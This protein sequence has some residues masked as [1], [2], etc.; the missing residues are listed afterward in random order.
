MEKYSLIV[1]ISLFSLVAQGQGNSPCTATL[2]T[3]NA[4]AVCGSYTAGTTVGATYSNNAANGGT[5][6]CAS[7]GAPDVWYYFVAP[8]SGNINIYTSGGSITDGGMQLY[9]SS[10]NLCSGTLTA[11]NCDDDSGPGWMPQLTLCGLTP[12]NT[13][14]VRFWQYGGAGTGTFN[15][16]FWDTYSN[17]VASTNCNGGAQVCSN[18][19]FT[20]LG[21]GG[22]VQELTACNAGCLG[23]ENNSSWYWLNIGTTGSLEMTITPS[24][25][26]DDYDFAIWGPISVCPPLTAP[27]RCNYAAYPRVAGCGTNTNP[28]GMTAAGTGTSA[29]SCQN[30]PYLTPL[31]VTAGQ[32]YILLIDGYTPSSQPFTLSWGGTAGLSCTPIVLPIELLSFTGKNSGS[33]N[34]LDWITTTEVNNDFFTLEKSKDGINFSE[35]KRVKGAGMS[36]IT[37]S[38]QIY[39]DEPYSGITYYRLKQTD[40]NGHSQTFDV[41]SVQSCIGACS[42]ASAYSNGYGGIV[43]NINEKESA[44]YTIKVFDLI[45]NKLL[46][47]TV[48]TQKGNNSLIIDAGA[49]ST[50]VYFVSFETATGNVT[51]QKLLIK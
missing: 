49:I 45:G 3:V 28:T 1:V 19:S 2:M 15:I 11:Y 24:N 30:R 9:G 29:T 44:F 33:R 43:V 37:N 38:Y 20:G 41:I 18:N 7:P 50:G 8:A 46:M 12:G 16:C 47:E 51:T 10:N 14:W 5:P 27:V 26:T 21:S 17:T 25:G 42:D 35:Y 13:Y 31:A 36:S 23:G 39:D 22:G 6:T 34:L 48:Y 40:F 4:G 32:T